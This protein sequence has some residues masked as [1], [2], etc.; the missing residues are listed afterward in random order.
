[1]P[2]R[3][4]GI[5]VH[6][7]SCTIAVMGPSGKRLRHW[8]VETDR[9]VLVEAIQRAALPPSVTSTSAGDRCDRATSSRACHPS[10][11][12]QGDMDWHSCKG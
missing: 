11:R 8:Q 12:C 5:D 7:S 2:L 4:I 10:A 3:H 1:M 9:R 6:T